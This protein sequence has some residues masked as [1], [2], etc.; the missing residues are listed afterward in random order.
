MK[1][2]ILEP[3]RELFKDEVRDLGRK[4][5]IKENLISR[6]PFPGPGLAIRIPG[7]ITIRKKFLFYKA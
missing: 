3:L 7:V 1:L 4:L 6:H 2:R 5:K